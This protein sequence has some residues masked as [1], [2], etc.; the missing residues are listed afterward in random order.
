MRYKTGTQL[1][2]DAE[3]M[4]YQ[5]AGTA[6]QMYSQ[7]VLLLNLQQAFDFLFM[8][9]WWPQF[10]VRLERT[11]LNGIPTVPITEISHYEDIRFVYAENTT[12]PLAKLPLG[13]NTLNQRMISGAVPRYIE[14][15]AT[16][17]IRCWPSESI[18]RILVVGRARPDEYLITDTFQMDS[19]LLT[20]YAVWS[21]FT[22]DASN[23][24]AA[25]KAKGLFDSRY[26]T[27]V[28]NT[29]N[30]PIRLD[31]GVGTIPDSWTEG[32]YP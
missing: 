12:T 10:R 13:I 28:N 16:N 7:D 9:Q 11:L 6:V 17:L 31:G 30:E 22:D 15:D 18:G 3:K 23:P 5:M 26:Q 29:F 20:A 19:Q 24:E 27:L 1:I 21:Y 32:P 14:A 4:L 25:I 8:E 2:I